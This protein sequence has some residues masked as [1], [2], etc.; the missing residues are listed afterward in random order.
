MPVQYNSQKLIPAPEISIQKQYQRDSAGDIIGAIYNITVVGSVMAYKGSP[1][2][3]GSFWT[4]SGYP[5]D[6]SGNDNIRLKNLLGKEE[7]LRKLFSTDGFSFEVQPWDGSAPIKFYPRIQSIDIPQ[8]LWFEKFDY[9]IV[10]EADEIHG[11]LLPSGE[12]SFGQ[13]ITSAD[14][15]WN[16]EFNDQGE[17]NLNPVSFRL[18]HNVSAVGKK[19]Y[20]VLG[21]STPSWQQARN[22]V[23]PRL[24]ISQD[25]ITGSGTLNL[26]S[27]YQGFN[28]VRSEQVD[29]PAGTFAVTESWILTSGSALENFT[30]QAVNNI[31]VGIV[32][33]SI[34]GIIQGLDTRDNNFQ[35]TTTKYEAADAKFGAIS[36]MI[37][38]RAQTFGGHSLNL[39]PVAI[40][41]GR[42]PVDGVIQ[43]NYDFDNRPTSLMNGALSEI[44]T[45]SD[46]HPNDIFA[47]VPIL[48]RAAG[49]ILQP[50]NTIGVSRRSISIELV[51]ATTTSTSLAAQLAEKPNTDA[52]VSDAKPAASSVFKD[53]DV[54]SWTPRFGRF[55]R[56]VSW[57]WQ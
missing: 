48:G 27:Y 9:T 20:D 46:T 3:D 35:L 13:Y 38:S 29:Q 37:F 26:P 18:T 42:N 28:H 16:L 12:D 34:Q 51:M 40:S 45:V 47:T 22:W 1:R 23:L 31:D 44:I 25:R 32:N 24:G 52:I 39:T 5:P 15:G 57:T 14:E 36:G 54:D 19:H 10:L 21:N 7:G 2:A 49:P 56:N 6:D 17:S 11:T 55:T 8:G 4:D 53:E 41:I 50:I 33:V 30:V 43:Y